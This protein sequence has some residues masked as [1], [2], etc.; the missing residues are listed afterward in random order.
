METLQKQLMS[1]YQPIPGIHDEFLQ[2]GQIR[3]HYDFLISSLDSL[4]TE[5][6]QQ[7]RNEAFRLDLLDKFNL[8]LPCC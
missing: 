3:P 6:L 1:G 8:E 7:R 2:N 4:G 5:R